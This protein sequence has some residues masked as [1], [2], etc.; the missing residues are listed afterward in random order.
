MGVQGASLRPVYELMYK[1]G[2][3]WDI[4]YIA[5]DNIPNLKSN[6]KL[7]KLVFEKIEERH[8]LFRVKRKTLKRY[9]PPIPIFITGEDYTYR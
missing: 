9:D 5:E 4:G 8:F 6:K 7:G 1:K 3:R 2:Y